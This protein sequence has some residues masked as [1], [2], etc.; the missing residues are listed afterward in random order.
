MIYGLLVTLAF[1]VPP[2][3]S[4]YLVGVASVVAALDLGTLVA[5]HR[6]RREYELAR[7]E[8]EVGFEDQLDNNRKR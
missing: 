3:F 8:M 5:T 2:W 1:W 6:H 7:D 4:G